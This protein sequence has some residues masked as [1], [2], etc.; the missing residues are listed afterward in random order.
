VL[1]NV[2]LFIAGCVVAAAL[3]RDRP[4]AYPALVALS[5]A[6]SVVAPPV[7]SLSLEFL[8]VLLMPLVV[9]LIVGRPAWVVVSAIVTPAL[10]LVRASDQA[11]NINPALLGIY[12]M[13]VAGITLA[14]V[15]VDSALRTAVG[16][17]RQAEEAQARIADHAQQLA[18]VNQQQEHRLDEQRKLLSLVATLETPAVTL[19]DGVLLVPIVGHLDSRRAQALTERLLRSTH[20]QRAHLVILDIAGVAV[21]DTAVTRALF[22]TI[23]ALRLLGCQVTISGISASIAMSLSQLGLSFAGITTVRSPQEA[24]ERR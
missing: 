13:L 8:L 23:Q 6:N 21:M 22:N 17:A 19:A 1:A 14:R 18:E 20:D 9:A 7:A 15:V 3:W 11:L 24:L 2:A 16:Y 12:V 5:I 4:M 10:F